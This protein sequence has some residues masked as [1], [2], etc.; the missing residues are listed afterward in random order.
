MIAVDLTECN[1][2]DPFLLSLGQA[3]VPNVLIGLR[4]SLRGQS[5]AHND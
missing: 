4:S 3:W 1:S 5:P 2:E